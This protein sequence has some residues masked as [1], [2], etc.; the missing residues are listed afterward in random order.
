MIER[1]LFKRQRALERVDDFGAARMASKA[2]DLG[3][4]QS[5]ATE[6]ARDRRR[7]MFFCEWRNGSVKNHPEPF[8]VDIP[9][10]DIECIGPSMLAAHFHC[11]DARFVGPQ[12]ACGRP[13]AEEGG[14]D[15]IR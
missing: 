9:A 8:R 4:S 5:R 10:H 6:N 2:I 13:V 11:C 1:A 15:N 12:Y 3:E 14:G 7:N